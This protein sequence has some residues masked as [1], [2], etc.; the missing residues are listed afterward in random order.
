MSELIYSMDGINQHLPKG[1]SAPAR[2]LPHRFV[3]ATGSERR[4]LFQVL[5]DPV[6][7]LVGGDA[8]VLTFPAQSGLIFTRG[9]AALAH[10][11][12]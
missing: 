10:H 6:E 2:Y 8:L 11:D 5:A 9:K 1:G 12:A 7:H 4:L 3:A